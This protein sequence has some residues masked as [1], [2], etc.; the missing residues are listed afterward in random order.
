MFCQFPSNRSGGFPTQ[1]VQVVLTSEAGPGGDYIPVVTFP[2]R[3]TST[4][5]RGGYSG[6]RQL[7]SVFLTEASFASA[8]MLAALSTDARSGSK[9][10]PPDGAISC[11]QIKY[12]GGL[13]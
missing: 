10:R 13:S 9:E 4:S 11:H 6:L 7:N 2:I 12:S 8:E 3:K 1:R 5:I